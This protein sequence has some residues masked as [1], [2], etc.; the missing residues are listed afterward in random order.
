MPEDDSNSEQGSGSQ[1]V[2]ESE[3]K[4]TR[5]ARVPHEIGIEGYS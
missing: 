4:V 3:R 1:E 2:K 5:E